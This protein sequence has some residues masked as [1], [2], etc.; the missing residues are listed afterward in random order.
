[1]LW[2]AVCFLFLSLYSC[3]FV[4][5]IVPASYGWG[6]NLIAFFMDAIVIDLK[7]FAIRTPE[8]VVRVFFQLYN[9][10]TVKTALWNLFVSM[11]VSNDNAMCDEARTALLFDHLIAL[12]DELEK[13]RAGE[14]SARHCVVCNG[15]R[16]VSPGK[17]S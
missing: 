1:M 13:L 17:G 12:V 3:L 8:Q 6:V 10:E 9:P 4:L 16:E 14:T 11:A 15:I 7:D 2:A 5:V